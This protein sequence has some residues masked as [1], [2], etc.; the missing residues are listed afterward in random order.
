[1]SPGFNSS[2]KIL[3][4]NFGIH[5]LYVEYHIIYILYLIQSFSCLI[6]SKCFV[7]AFP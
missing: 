2:N 7:I 3:Q 5:F 1:M 4:I 6:L